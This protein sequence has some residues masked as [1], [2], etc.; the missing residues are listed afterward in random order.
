LPT[1][2]DIEV[3]EPVPYSLD[4]AEGSVA[5]SSEAASA[6][7]EAPLFAD[8]DTELTLTGVSIGKLAVF[9]LAPP[10]EF[11]ELAADDETPPA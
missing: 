7:V 1:K 9:V 5:A 4:E 11:E 2:G 6:V 3:P 8:D 10:L